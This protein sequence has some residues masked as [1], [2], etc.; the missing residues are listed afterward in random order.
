M[1][2]SPIYLFRLSIAYDEYVGLC[3]AVNNGLQAAAVACGASR[4]VPGYPLPDLLNMPTASVRMHAVAA[5]SAGGGSG[6]SLVSAGPVTRQRV[7]NTDQAVLDAAASVGTPAPDPSTSAGYYTAGGYEPLAAA[8]GSTGGLPPPVPT[9]I[10]MMAPGMGMV[11]GTGMVSIDFFETFSGSD[12][13]SI[14]LT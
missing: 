8:L 4:M 10:P 12:E 7:L 14:L 3:E 5:A 11:H 6:D 13:L 2:L 9:N 1:I